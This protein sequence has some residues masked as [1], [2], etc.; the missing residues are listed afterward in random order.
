MQCL[1][2][3]VLQDNQPGCQEALRP[4]CQ[5]GGQQHRQLGEN[6]QGGIPLVVLPK[7]PFRPLAG[8]RQRRYGLFWQWCPLW[9]MWGHCKESSPFVGFRWG[10]LRGEQKQMQSRHGSTNRSCWKLDNICLQPRVCQRSC[11]NQQ[12]GTVVLLDQ[13]LS[14]EQKQ[15]VEI[16]PLIYI[17][18]FICFSIGLCCPGAHPPV[19]TLHARQLHPPAQD[20]TLSGDQSERPSHLVCS[21]RSL[22]HCVRLHQGPHHSHPVS[23]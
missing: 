7:G 18:V 22:S 9:L 14:W 20:G 19:R 10:F 17:S 23:Q 3:G 4:V 8:I 11:P 16:V 1:P 15:N 6:H 21:G 2:T 13:H 12:R 5:G